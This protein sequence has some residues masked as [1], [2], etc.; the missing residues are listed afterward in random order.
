ML[1]DARNSLIGELAAG[2]GTEECRT[3]FGD[4]LLSNQLEAG[5]EGVDDLKF[6]RDV[7]SKANSFLH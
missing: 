7:I 6:K 4:Q 2:V 3:D 5:L 1:N